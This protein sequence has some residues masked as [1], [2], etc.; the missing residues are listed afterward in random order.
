L[1][2]EESSEDEYDDVDDY[3][4]YSVNVESG[5]YAG[6]SYAIKVEYD[7]DLNDTTVN[8]G[9]T[10]KRIDIAVTAPNEQIYNFSAYRGSY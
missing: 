6:Y 3:N 1:G 7:S 8:D 2:P 4:G 10:F 5:S 9:Q